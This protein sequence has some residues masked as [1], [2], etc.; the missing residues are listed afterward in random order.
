MLRRQSARRVER[1]S[2]ERDLKHAEQIQRDEHDQ[3]GEAHHKDRAT[4]LHSPAGPMSGRLDTDDNGGQHEKRHEHTECI[5]KT[6]LAHMPWFAS[7]FADET[8]NFQRDDRQDAW[9]D[10]QNQP[11]DEGVEQH[12]PERL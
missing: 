9:H 6:E 7:G 11:A 2:A 5:D 3:R 10:V 8:E 1:A 12:L 4:E